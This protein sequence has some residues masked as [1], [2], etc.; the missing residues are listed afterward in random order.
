MA[1]SLVT[2]ADVRNFLQKPDPDQEQDAIIGRLIE[3]ASE[4]VMT[5]AEREFAPES[6]PS[7]ARQFYYCG[8]G[9]LSLTPY[10]LQ[11]L[12]SVKIDT[13][14]GAGGT[15]LA[16]TE[17][18]LKPKP[19][20]DGVY[21]WLKL[22]PV[23]SQPSSRF[24]EREVTVTGTW[25]FPAVPDDVKHWTTVTVAEWLRLHVQAFSTTFNIDEQRLER[26]EM[27]PSAVRA[28]LR[29]YRMDSN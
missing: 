8:N 9:I 24:A 21:N 25:G 17:Y 16:A 28:G 3:S 10:D 14:E 5:Y 2:V 23:T 29:R 26:P 7:T 19:A 4:A 6:A 13:T 27:L 1:V 15:T 18:Q 11:T 20:R 12:V 22:S